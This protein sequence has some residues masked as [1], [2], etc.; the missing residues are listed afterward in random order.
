MRLGTRFDHRTIVQ[1]NSSVDPTLG[2]TWVRGYHTQPVNQEN[3][4]RLLRKLDS[5]P[6]YI[7]LM[8]RMGM[9]LHSAAADRQTYRENTIASFRR[10][11]AAGVSFVEFDVQVGYAADLCMV[12]L[13]C[14]PALGHT[15]RTRHCW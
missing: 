14:W 7:R 6:C 4:W 11:A 15:D 13:A 9:N 1:S 10:A 5:K 2:S 12:I 3:P 8:C